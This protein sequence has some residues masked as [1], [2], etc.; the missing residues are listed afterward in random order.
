MF[1]L[2]PIARTRFANSVTDEDLVRVVETKKKKE[3]LARLIE[4]MR[5]LTTQLSILSG[6][7]VYNRPL[8]RSINALAIELVD[9]LPKRRIEAEPASFGTNIGLPLAENIRAYKCERE[10][11]STLSKLM[12]EEINKIMKKNLLQGFF[13]RSR[14]LDTISYASTD[15]NEYIFSTKEYEMLTGSYPFNL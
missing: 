5:W 2:A 4:K 1:G 15:I 7:R 10:T 12:R 9:S 6:G 3:E 13:R 8:K 11:L 14:A